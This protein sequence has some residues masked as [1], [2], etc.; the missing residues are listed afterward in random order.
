MFTSDRIRV[1]VV[2]DT[3]VCADALTRCLD[4]DKSIEVVA[5]GVWPECT[6]A[7]AELELD[8]VLLHLHRDNEGI[9]A[10]RALRRRLGA[11]LVALGIPETE[12]DVVR[13]A[14]AGVSTYLAREGS[15]DEL[16][17]IV[18]DAARGEVVSP[19]RIVGALVERIATLSGISR[20]IATLT[21]RERQVLRLL[22]E[23]LS[24]KEIA[25]HLCIEA[26]TVKNHVHRI[27]KK[28]NVSTRGAAAAALA[29][30]GEGGT[31]PE[32]DPVRDSVGTGP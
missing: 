22:D 24:N 27:L 3:R 23:G 14:E 9:S 8:V 26:A 32:P 16:G 19:P 28:L 2:A 11:R 18:T 20:E 13:Y 29:A 21:P 12:R 6:N 30:A 25:G 15:L 5:A 10:A 4:P 17:G 7:V 31:V 1:A